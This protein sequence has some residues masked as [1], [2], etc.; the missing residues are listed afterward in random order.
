MHKLLLAFRNELRDYEKLEEVSK[1]FKASPK[2]IPQF[3][4]DE[5]K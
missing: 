1:K 2:Q 5:G 3:K 4:K